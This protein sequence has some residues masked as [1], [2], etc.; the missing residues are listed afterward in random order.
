[1]ATHIVCHE[2]GRKDELKIAMWLTRHSTILT[3]SRTQSTKLRA[4]L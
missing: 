4:R 3:I 2:W 1:V